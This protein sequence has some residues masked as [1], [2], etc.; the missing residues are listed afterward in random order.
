MFRGMTADAVCYQKCC[1]SL[2]NSDTI[3]SVAFDDENPAIEVK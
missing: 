2:F 3:D 1:L